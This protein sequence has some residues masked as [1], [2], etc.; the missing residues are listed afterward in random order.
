[1]KIAKGR[2]NDFSLSVFIRMIYSCLV[3]ADFLDTEA[4]MKNGQTERALGQSLDVLLDKLEKYIS[5]WLLNDDL[6][7]TLFG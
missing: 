7:E 2:N 3:D 1:M 4:F 6:N 5:T